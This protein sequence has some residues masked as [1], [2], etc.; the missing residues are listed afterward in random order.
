MRKLCSGLV[1]GLLVFLALAMAPEAEAQVAWESPLLVSPET[2]A[3][4][5]VYLTDPYPGNGIGVLST[6]R[7][8]SGPGLGYR[9][10]IAEDRGDDVSVFAGLDAS[11]MIMTASNEFPFNMAWVLGAGLGV[12]DD[13]LLSF[14][15]AL[16]LGRS[17]ESDGVWFNPYVSPRVT[18]DAFFGDGND[19]DLGLSVDLGIDMSFDPGWAIRFGGTLGDRS[20]LAIGMSF[21]VL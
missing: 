9:L 11:G 15:L 5:G 2:P 12:G 10:G 20:A 19:L 21:R 6:W 14:P 1:G 13:V 17:V 18:L 3:G 7:S 16:T 8:R 4:W